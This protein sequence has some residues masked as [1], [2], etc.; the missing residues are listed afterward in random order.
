MDL[1]INMAFLFLLSNTIDDVT[2]SHRKITS[3][4]LAFR[5]KSPG[6]RPHGCFSSLV[7]SPAWQE[8]AASESQG[9]TTFSSLARALSQ[10][11]TWHLSHESMCEQDLRFLRHMSGIQMH[12]KA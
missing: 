6:R 10:S 3:R 4:W 2:V 7:G 12:S 9:F 5:V 11:I 8:R 1:E